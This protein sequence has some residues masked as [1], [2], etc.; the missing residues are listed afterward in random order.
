MKVK[1]ILIV[2]SDPLNRW[3]IT[4]DCN[5]IIRNTSMTKK[6]KCNKCGL[7]MCFD[8]R[9]AWHG[10]MSCAQALDTE[11]KTYSKQKNVKL[12]PKCKTRIE[13]NEGCNHMTC[14]RCNHQFCWLCG[15]V[16]TTTHF[17]AVTTEN[18][19][20][21]PGMQNLQNE[22]EYRR[23]KNWRTFK[24]GCKKAAFLLWPIGVLFFFV[25]AICL[26]FP[27]LYS[28]YFEPKKTRDYVILIV[29]GILG[30]PLIPISLILIIFPG[31]WLMYREYKK[32]KQGK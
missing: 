18:P 28:V 23:F 16:Y 5:N 15:G 32:R 6:I 14:S 29:I 17:S 12:C 4:P 13:K 31:S 2:N 22:A 10:R 20:G 8:C 27:W 9:G 7:E 21:C 11:I 30:I 26:L 1:S 25:F 3:C 19:W 24:W